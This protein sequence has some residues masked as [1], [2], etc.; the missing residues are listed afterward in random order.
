MSISKKIHLRE[1]EEVLEILRRYLLTY[2]HTYIFGLVLI[3]GATFFITWLFGQGWW[4]MVLYGLAVFCGFFI[5]FQTWYFARQNMLVITGQRVV[6][7]SRANWL[8]EV[9]SS[10]GYS[11]IMDISFRKRGLFSNLFNY[12][13]IYIQTKSKQFVLEISKIHQPQKAMNFIMEQVEFYRDGKG[14]L[15]VEEIYNKFIKIIPELT[16]DELI[17]VDDIIHDQLE[18]ELVEG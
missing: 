1:G 18:E 12:G 11:D 10:V 6:D 13:D 5:I 3:T 2:F 9:V 7:I 15:T 14:E 17:G 16:D 4:G 8:D